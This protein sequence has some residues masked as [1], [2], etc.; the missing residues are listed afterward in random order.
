MAEDR[1]PLDVF[2]SPQN[3]AVIGATEEPNSAGRTVLWNLVS[4]PFGGTVFPVNPKRV[5]VL[6]IKA[7]PNLQAVPARVDLAVI[8]TPAERVPGIIS[9][10]ADAGVEG[11]IVI[12]SGFRERD[13]AG[14]ELEQQIINEAR[15]GGV[16]LIG[17]ASF[18]VMNARNGL[19]ASFARA[20]VH[21]GHVAFISQS[22]AL[23]TAVLDWSLR[24]NIGFSVFVSV[25]S[26][27]DIG[28]GDL[29]D[30]LAGDPRTQ[31]IVIYMEAIDDARAFLSAAR[32]AALNKPIIVLKAG[33]ANNG[34]GGAGLIAASDEVFD[35]AF[36]RCGVLRVTTI[37][38]LFSMA[39]VL[40][41][42]ARPRGPRLT[43]IT[44]AGGPSILASDALLATGGK[45]A[46]LASTTLSAL[47][48][49][50]PPDWSH[51]NPID[52][53]S[54]A[55]PDRYAKALE[56]AGADPNSDGV[57]II[58]APQSAS[59]P[60]GTAEQIA[61]LAPKLKGKPILA[62]WMGGQAIA[63]GEAILNQAGI[64]TFAYP[65]AAAYSFL[66]MWRYGEYLRAIYET[67][68][69][70]E[71]D[72]F[73]APDRVL[74]QHL[75]RSAR[76]TG[77]TNLSQIDAKRLLV[78][79]GIPAAETRVATSEGSAV[80]HASK[81]GY[82]VVL[83]PHTLN[84]GD[85]EVAGVRL[86][87]ASAAAVRRAFRALRAATGESFHS[88]SI[89]P[90]IDS[91]GFELLIG[92][93][94]DQQFGPV[95]R[96]GAG[97]RTA[98]AIHDYAL[99]LPPLNTTL[100]RRM[101]ERTRIYR[102]LR[103]ASGHHAFDLGALEYLLVRL[104]QLVVEQPAIKEILVNPLLATAQRL[105]ALDAQIVIYG[106][107]LADADLPRPAI[108]PYPTHY[109][110]TWVAK[111]GRE[112]TFRPIRPED[113][114]LLVAFHATLSEESVYMRYF[115]PMKLS[116]RISH[117]RLTRICFIDYDREMALV[118]ERRNPK[119]GTPAILA[120][121]RL[122]KLLGTNDSEFA[123]LVSD[124][125]QGLGLG[126]ELL[127]R[128]I[129]VGRDEKVERIVGDILADNIAMQRVCERLGFTL[130]RMFDGLVKAEL[131]LRR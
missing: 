7:Y 94:P 87:L 50:L 25:G 113:E 120:V 115:F 39:E 118:A 33:R 100:A 42:Q 23:C 2:F 64:P 12:A 117:E 121:G 78:A 62:S 24:E 10:C 111:D 130:R 51:A 52:L 109:I 58:L 11:V 54:D 28:W 79:Y 122:A 105:V 102:A 103:D 18:G 73:G 17:P 29:I 59:D 20:M 40:A 32:E 131:P 81:L 97:G 1:H 71:D 93:Q 15:R 98:H 49:E 124:D 47:D 107:E 108:R 35:A 82:P 66:N 110:G 106:P 76:R 22:G 8:T 46:Q 112:V 101:I 96:F 104:S 44:N 41:R 57:L 63:Q 6:G 127:R 123:T 114:P 9:E 69:L 84:D 27:L 43:I 5:S 26:M 38:N 77:H 3:V 34:A 125:Y 14:L 72:S 60:T 53:L 74:A 90:H 95:L 16:R 89:Q 37:A 55:G 67:P 13:A 92:S 75:I 4:S 116:Q 48:A 36:R 99:A 119:T 19:N 65:D 31:S 68:S 129:Q 91:E 88:V 70:P 56:Y 61:G 83:Q 80:A 30:Y 126:T 86:H 45:L 128:L 21:P 85:D